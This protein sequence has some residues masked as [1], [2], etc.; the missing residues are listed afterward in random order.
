MENGFLGR[1]KVWINYW[2]AKNEENEYIYLFIYFLRKG[3]IENGF[4]RMN[5]VWINYWSANNEE[6]KY[7]YIYIY[8]FLKREKVKNEGFFLDSREGIKFG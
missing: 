2:S 8:L 7:I 3:G 5:K 4:L 6:S 1:N